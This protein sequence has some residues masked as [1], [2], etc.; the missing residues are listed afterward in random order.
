MII[1][2]SYHDSIIT[3]TII[4]IIISSMKETTRF[5]GF[6]PG[7]E[8]TSIAFLTG[9]PGQNLFFKTVWYHTWYIGTPGYELKVWKFDRHNDEK[10][11]VF[12]WILKATKFNYN[13]M[14]VS[15]NRGTP[16]G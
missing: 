7:S 3:I 15:K 6:L 5:V 16:K 13:H 11:P 1:L 12:F 10:I 9:C 8:K 4:I 2:L 14:D